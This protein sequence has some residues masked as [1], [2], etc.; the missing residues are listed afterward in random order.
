V[1]AFAVMDGRTMDPLGM[2]EQCDRK[3]QAGRRDRKELIHDDDLMLSQL[4]LRALLLL[5]AWWERR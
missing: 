2:Q 5:R 1:C 3:T 4:R